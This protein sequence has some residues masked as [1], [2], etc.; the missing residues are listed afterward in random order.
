MKALRAATALLPLL[1]ACGTTPRA[2]VPSPAGESRLCRIGPDGG[3]PLD[4]AS[5]DRGIGGTGILAASEDRGIGGTG[6]IGVITGFASICVNGMRVGY[7]PGLPVAFGD[8]IARPDTLRAG[9]VVLI[10]AGPYGGGLRAERVT[11]RYEVSGPVEAVEEGAIRVAGQRV[12]YAGLLSPMTPW[13]VGDAVQ[14]SGM[15]ALDGSISAT[16]I[17]RQPEGS[18]PRAVTLHGVL[19]RQS[20]IARIGNL[21]LRAGPGVMLPDGGPVVASGQIQDGVLIVTSVTPDMLMRDPSIWFGPGFDRFVVEGYVSVGLG[22]ISWG[23]G[24]G[25]G[26]P[27]GLGGV[28]PGHGVVDLR[29]G[30]D[31]R[32]VATGLR[33]GFGMAAP[34][35]FRE[36]PAAG[37]GAFFPGRQG[38]SPRGEPAPMPDRSFEARQ[39]LDR[40]GG[41][42]SAAGRANLQGRGASTFRASDRQGRGDQGGGPSG[43]PAQF[44]P[45]GAPG[46]GPGGPSQGP[47]RP[48]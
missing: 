5:D 30:S 46:S 23:S 26:A 27:A 25:A 24:L 1:G 18:A 12:T 40:Q 47:G 35:V 31:G 38:A 4:T 17:D 44:G 41:G 45:A 10:A 39:G 2:P 3:P 21:P 22:R 8:V 34:G 19:S 20:G 28:S 11:V 16:R 37:G 7:A 9:Q 32:L 33:D 29:R 6:I 48:R 14:V 36:G 13:R 42:G 43:E 15:R